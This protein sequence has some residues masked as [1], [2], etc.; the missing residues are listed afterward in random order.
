MISLDKDKI[1][2][3]Q[4]AVSKAVSVLSFYKWLEAHCLAQNCGT[5]DVF[6]FQNCGTEDVQI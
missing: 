2:V 6:F 1:D 5:E 3:D 4:T